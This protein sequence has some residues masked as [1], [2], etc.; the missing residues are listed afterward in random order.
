MNMKCSYDTEMEGPVG[1]KMY[2]AVEVNWGVEL[3]KL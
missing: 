2:P 3:R 1:S